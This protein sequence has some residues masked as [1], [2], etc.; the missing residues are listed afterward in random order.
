MCEVKSLKTSQGR[1]VRLEGSRGEGLKNVV[2][3]DVKKGFQLMVY[4]NIRS[5]L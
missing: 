3:R 1:Q 4:G 5:E 2:E